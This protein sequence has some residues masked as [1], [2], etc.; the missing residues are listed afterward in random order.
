MVEDDGKG[1]SS[2]WTM[3]NEG[4]TQRIGQTEGL[5]ARGC[6]M[7]D[8]HLNMMTRRST[9]DKEMKSMLIIE[10]KMVI[11]PSEGR[12]VSTW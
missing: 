6:T 11:V 3:G 10:V 12:C 7:N 9:C 4:Q 1:Q 5:K 2:R 8:K